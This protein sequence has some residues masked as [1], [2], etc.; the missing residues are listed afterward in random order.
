MS[1]SSAESVKIS[2]HLWPK[3]PVGLAGFEPA[4]CRAATA[5][6]GESIEPVSTFSSFVKSLLC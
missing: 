2:V 6:Q 5:L 1:Q 3:N 4:T